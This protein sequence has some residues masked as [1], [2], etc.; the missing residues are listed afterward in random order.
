M[1]LGAAVSGVAQ[2]RTQLKRLSSSSRGEINIRDLDC[3]LLSPGCPLRTSLLPQENRSFYCFSS[4]SSQGVRIGKK[5]RA[6]LGVG[7]D[8]GTITVP[9]WGQ[10]GCS[11]VSWLPSSLGTRLFVGCPVSASCQISKLPPSSLKALAGVPSTWATI[12][13]GPC[14]LHDLPDQLNLCSP[15]QGQ[16]LLFSGTTSTSRVGRTGAASP[17]KRLC[18]KT[19]ALSSATKR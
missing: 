4:F 6:V 3:F 10:R 12:S 2:S 17:S 9:G 8:T 15:H 19:A 16:S 5:D 18:T 7:D 11:R 13:A 1:A 14:S